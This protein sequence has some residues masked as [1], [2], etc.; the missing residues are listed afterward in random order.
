MNLMTDWRLN[1]V[2]MIVSCSRDMR[3]G[4]FNWDLDMDDRTTRLEEQVT[5]FQADLSQMSDELYAQQREI[6]SLRQEIETL[7]SRLLSAQS[8][9]DILTPEED[10]PPPHY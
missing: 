8:D 7:K 3:A 2:Y 6:V 5:L 4:H 9:G 1:H 10:S